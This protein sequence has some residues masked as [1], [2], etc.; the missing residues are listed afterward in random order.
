MPA[1]LPRRKRQLLLTVGLGL[2]FLGGTALLVWRLTRPEPIYRPGEAIEGLTADLARALPADYPRVRLEDVTEEAGIRFRHFSGSRS[3]QLPEDMGSGAAWGDYD[4]DGWL[5]LYVAN[6][7]GPLTLTAEEV[8]RSPAHSVL[9]HN[10]GDG[11][12]TEVGE[13][14]GVRFRGWAMGVGWGD[15]DNDGWLDLI[16]TAFGENALYRNNGD[17][18]FTE[19]A[20]EAGLGGIERFWAGA[21]WGDYQRDG[22]LDLH[23]AG[24]VRY[25]RL[26]DPD[27]G[28]S[29]HYDVEEPASIN[30]SAFPPER[31]LLYRNNGNGTFTEVAVQA[32]VPGSKGRSLDAVWADFDQDGWPDLYVANDVSDNVLYRNEGDGTFSDISHAARVADYRGAM[33]I[34]VG[35]WNGDAELDMVVTHW[36]AQENALYTNLSSGGAGPASTAAA[37]FLSFRDEADRFGLGQIALDFIGFGTSFFDYDNDGRLDLFFANGS[38]F[39]RRDDPSLLVAM[40]DQLFWNRGP[41]E[42]F[43]DVSSVSGEYFQREYGGRGAAF[44]DYDNDGDVDVFIVNNGGPGILLRN[45]GGNGNRWLQVRLEGRQSNRSAFGARLRLVAGG[46]VQVR[47]VGS[48]ASYLSQN[49]LTEHFGL[50]DAERA[51]TL[52]ITWPSGS[53][54][55]LV[56][57]VADQILEVVEGEEPAKTAAG[58]DRERV[59]RFWE[60]Y[61][62][63][64]DH[65]VAGRTREAASTYESALELKDDH[66]DALYYLG[67]MYVDLGEH[68]S[69]EEAWRRLVDVSRSS[70]RA[71]SRLGDLYRCAELDEFFDLDAAEAEF[72]RA[73]DINRE[74]FGP[75]LQLGQVALLSG[76]L[77]SARAY[78]DA[79]IG[80]NESSVDAHFYRGYMEWKGGDT[81]RGRESFVRAVSLAR[82]AEPADGMSREGDTRAGSAP[83]VV[84]T[85]ICRGLRAHTDDLGSVEPSA[86]EAEAEQ[87]YRRL[88]RY[89]DEVRRKPGS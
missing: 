18:T 36:M 74:D 7:A 27:A 68:A 80:S 25:D 35:D 55:V 45:D 58:T 16:V 44:A 1:A 87:S 69:A 62:E 41:D 63:A 15:Y 46:T 59:L 38:T 73:L 21:S 13:Q 76:D 8:E 40:P 79:V 57:I 26:A 30:P 51:D 75:V 42:G 70:A 2:V 10:N 85:S 17:G 81:Q 77:S 83:L 78:F 49:S 84:S 39:Q 88:D 66:E 64:T 65:R 72:R 52:E 67:N 32:G 71:H 82:P 14:A 33:G 4:N 56:D 47:E 50:A 54:Q 9:Y 31:N 20:V 61:R 53:R 48:Q 24:Y 5:D 29:L 6:M 60:L 43:Y 19:R 22:Y 37:S 11:T 34:A 86:A 3:T 89:L 23:V 12:F 28:V